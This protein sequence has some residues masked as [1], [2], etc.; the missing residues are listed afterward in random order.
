MLWRL[1]V[2]GRTKAGGG[3]RWGGRGQEGLQR[4]GSTGTTIKHCYDAMIGAISRAQHLVIMPLQPLFILLIQVILHG[5][6]FII[7]RG[8]NIP[9]VSRPAS[10]CT[11]CTHN[12][13]PV[14]TLQP[15][16]L[17]CTVPLQDARHTSSRATSPSL[18]KPV[19]ALQVS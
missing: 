7:R 19:V 1:A 8:H 9:D 14:S 11:L 4:A 15:A 18:F 6:F 10:C 16:A 3:F 17:D 13:R 5:C 12:C 2:R